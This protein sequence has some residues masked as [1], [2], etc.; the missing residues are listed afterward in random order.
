MHQDAEGILSEGPSGLWHV[1]LFDYVARI[2]IVDKNGRE[3]VCHFEANVK[4][5][6]PARAW[7]IAILRALIAEEK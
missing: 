3:K 4:D 5:Q 2:K 6:C 1:R 7:L